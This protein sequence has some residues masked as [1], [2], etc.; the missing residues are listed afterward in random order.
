MA[1]GAVVRRYSDYRD[2]GG[3]RLPH[4]VEMDFDGQPQPDQT[5]VF[6]S[7]RF[8]VDVPDAIFTRPA[9]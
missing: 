9:K 5:R 4:R 2:T 6:D 1:F 3:L 8:D 7:I